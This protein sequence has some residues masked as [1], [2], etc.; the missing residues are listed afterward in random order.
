MLNPYHVVGVLSYHLGR[1][2]SFMQQGNFPSIR[3][4][5]IEI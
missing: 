3:L 4:Y 1:K 5:I 2:G